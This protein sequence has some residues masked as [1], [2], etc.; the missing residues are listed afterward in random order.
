[1]S[2]REQNNLRSLLRKINSRLSVKEGLSTEQKDLRNI[3]AVFQGAELNFGEQL[4]CVS[5]MLQAI[6]ST[7]E[8]ARKLELPEGTI[9]KWVIL[10]SVCLSKFLN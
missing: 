7:I 9:R 1:M 8:V 10:E 2:A 6:Q 4:C 3:S 5:R